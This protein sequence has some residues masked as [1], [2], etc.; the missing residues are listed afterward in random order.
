MSEPAKLSKQR[1]R[2]FDRQQVFVSLVCLQVE[3]LQ[4]G[5][6]SISTTIYTLIL[7][8]RSNLG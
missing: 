8:K 5:A 7:Q 2:Q 6:Y 1:S 3:R 4:H